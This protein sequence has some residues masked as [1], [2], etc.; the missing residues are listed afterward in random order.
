MR[1]KLTLVT[2]TPPQTRRDALK[3]VRLVFAHL[4]TAYRD[5]ANPTAR[6]AMQQAAYFAG[7]AFTRAYVGYVHAVA[8]AIGGRY[9][10]AH[11]V[12]CAVAM[13]A[14]LRAYGHA[15][16]PQLAEL[17]VAAGIS[18][19]TDTVV[20]K[21]E[22]FLTALEELNQLLGLPKFFAQLKTEDIPMLAEQA[23]REGNLAYPAPKVLR[24]RDLE[25]LLSTL[26]P[27]SPL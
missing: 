15:A 8:H 25:A 26:S 10:V 4:P 11:G 20:G 21:A 2:A 19:Q 18:A 14:T 23:A 27:D 13:P 12:A 24:K 17:A 6:A 5:G 3:A 1:L 7:L 9:G 22:A 16:D